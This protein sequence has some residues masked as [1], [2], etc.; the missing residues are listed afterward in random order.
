MHPGP[1]DYGGLVGAGFGDDSGGHQVLDSFGE[2]LPGGGIIGPCG[3]DGGRSECGVEQMRLGKREVDVRPANGPKSFPRLSFSSAACRG[4]IALLGEADRQSLPRGLGDLGEE[5]LDIGKVPIYRSG[6]DA[7][8]LGQGPNLNPLRSAATSLVDCGCD[9]RVAQGAVVVTVGGHG[10]ILPYMLTVFTSGRMICVRRLH[11]EGKAEMTA[12]LDGRRTADLADRDEIV[13]F[14]IGMRINRLWQVWRWLPV[15]AA[16]PRMIIELAKDPS[17]GLLVAPRTMVSGRIILLVQYW[18]SF[19]DLERYARDPQ[20]QHLPAW[21]RFNRKIRDNGS[22]G[23]FHETYR[24]PTSSIESVYANMPIFGLAAATSVAPVT[25][26][27]HTA[28]A[29]LGARHDDQ[30]PVTIY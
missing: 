6:R 26:G 3:R 9:D 4:P 17:R 20:S 27:R 24:V 11:H 8:R 29:R 19:D 28:A 5:G 2:H 15:L 14:L 10:V 7:D 22:V 1:G 30:S 18:N 13:V 23:I 16:M 21:R 25:A 12:V